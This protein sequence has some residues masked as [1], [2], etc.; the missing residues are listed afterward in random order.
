MFLGEF[1]HSVDEKGRLIIPAKFRSGLAE[2]MVITRGLDACLWVF[3]PEEWAPL[4]ERISSLPV[5]NVSFR[6]FARLMF[7]GA[8][9]VVPD[10]QG[11]VLIPAYLRRY[12]QLDGD[13]VIIGLNRR[14]EIWNRDR[15]YERMARVESDADGLA[16]HLADLNVGI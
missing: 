6:D 3:P 8:A 11:R 9:E 5:T 2:G 12:A 10:A 4:A 14:L 15:W 7:A 1:E 16:Q 13:V